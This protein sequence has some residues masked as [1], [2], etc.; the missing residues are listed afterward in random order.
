MNSKRV[1]KNFKNSWFLRKKFFAESSEIVT[2][3]SEAR[4]KKKMK[5]SDIDNKNLKKSDFDEKKVD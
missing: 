3:K 4:M 2:S 1:L 5:K